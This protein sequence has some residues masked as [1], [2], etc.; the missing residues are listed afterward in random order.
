M[1]F[2]P[3]G[4]QKEIPLKPGRYVIGRQ[5]GVTLRLPFPSVSR[6]HCELMVKD[7]SVRVR[8][9]GSSNGTFRNGERVTEAELAAGDS[10]VVGGLGMGIRI[11][12]QPADL[13]APAPMGVPSPAESALMKTPPKPLAAQAGTEDELVDESM[14]SSL[15]PDESSMIDLDLDLDDTDAPEL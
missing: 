12:G 13:E 5:E 8:D 9:L 15:G 10:L 14:L 2:K 4:G 3:H 11:D 1:I 6:E 7:G